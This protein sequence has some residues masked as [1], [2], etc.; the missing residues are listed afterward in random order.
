M[1]QRHLSLFI[2]YSYRLLLSE[3]YVTRVD[4]ALSARIWRCLDFTF[5]LP[6]ALSESEKI[7]FLL[8]ELVERTGSYA[9]LRRIRAPSD[10]PHAGPRSRD[11]PSIWPESTR[12]AYLPQLFQPKSTEDS[13]SSH[14]QSHG[15]PSGI[16]DSNTHAHSSHNSPYSQYAELADATQRPYNPGS[17]R[18]KGPLGAVPQVDWGA[19]DM[20][21]SAQNLSQ[22]TPV[23][24]T[25][26]YNFGGFA[27]TLVPANSQPPLPPIYPACSTEKHDSS[28]RKQMLTPVGT[29]GMTTS[30]TDALINDIDWVSKFHVCMTLDCPIPPN[31][32]AFVLLLTSQYRTNGTNFL[33][34]PRW[35]LETS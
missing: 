5:E 15:S 8:T 18:N 10:M 26:P 24:N 4:P 29:T 30:S 20:D 34:A 31:C 28:T 14:E 11:S 23:T 6:S 17:F 25:E 3:M 35:G 1:G 13:G 27:P 32:L 21:M 19:V 16:G 12:H 33:E 7:R 9:S 22:L 2:D